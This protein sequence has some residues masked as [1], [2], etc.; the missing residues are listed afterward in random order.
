M[1]GTG[2]KSSLLRLRLWKAQEEGHPAH[3]AESGLVVPSGRTWE[4]RTAQGELRGLS[5]SH[6]SI[7]V[8]VTEPC[9]VGENS[10]SC[11]FRI[12]TFLWLILCLIQK[13]KN[14]ITS[15]YKFSLEKGESLGLRLCRYLYICNCKHLIGSGRHAGRR[16]EKKPRKP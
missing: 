4:L 5:M 3:D 2:T 13:F 10:P 15:K 1:E 6:F 9:L 12:H 7:G 14:T 11:A 16:R 8:L